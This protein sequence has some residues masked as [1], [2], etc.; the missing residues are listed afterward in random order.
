M[1]VKEEIIVKLEEVHMVGGVQK[2]GVRHECTQATLSMTLLRTIS[3][4]FDLLL[5]PLN[6][7]NSKTL[8]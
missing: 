8:F 5:T 2:L 3:V 4:S 1:E 7:L 6:V